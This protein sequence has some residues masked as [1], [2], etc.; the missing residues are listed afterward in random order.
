MCQCGNHGTGNVARHRAAASASPASIPMVGAL[1]A[2]VV[3]HVASARCTSITGRLGTVTMS[4]SAF[5]MSPALVSVAETVGVNVRLPASIMLASLN[6][7]VAVQCSECP[8]ARGCGRVK[9]LPVLSS[10]QLYAVRPGTP[11]ETCEARTVEMPNPLSLAL[12]VF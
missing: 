2:G 10:L 8:A 11:L 5:W 1:R 4:A 12:P 7:Y 6:V 3:G 9:A